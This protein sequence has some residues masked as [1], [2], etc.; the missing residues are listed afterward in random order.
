MSEYEEIINLLDKYGAKYVVSENDGHTVKLKLHYC[1]Q[2]D[3]Y[4]DEITITGA[5]IEATKAYLTPK[6]AIDTV[7]REQTEYNYSSDGEVDEYKA[8]RELRNLLKSHSVA[9][10]VCDNHR[11][12][13][14]SW[15]YMNGV[16]EAIFAEYHDGVT[17]F[18]CSTEGFNP[19][20]AVNATIGGDNFSD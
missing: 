1:E 19:K 2:C 5:C 4:L 12:H 20:Q 13:L 10:E 15:A 16:K 9:Y 8:T 6:Q 3:D 17:K 18:V 7:L 14:T 11:A